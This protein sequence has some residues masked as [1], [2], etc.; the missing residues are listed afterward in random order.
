MNQATKGARQPK[1]S[2]IAPPRFAQRLL[3]W[4]CHP[5]LLEEI[6]GDLYEQFIERV[7][8]QGSRKAKW[9]YLLE[10]IR[11]VRPFT[12][13]RDAAPTQP[14]MFVD[15]IRSYL[16]M[17]WRNLSR[18]TGFALLSLFGLAI[19]MCVCFLILLFVHDELGYDKFHK[20]ADRIYRVTGQAN[21]IEIARTPPPLGPL[22]TGYFPEIEQA[23]RL[24][25]RSASLEA[26]DEATPGRM[27]ELYQEERFYFADSTV[28]RIFSFH[29]LQGDSLG[30]LNE[31][32][33]VVITEKMARK[34]FGSVSPMGRTLIFEG[35]YPFK[36]SGV[37]KEFPAQSHLHFDFMASYQSMF[38]LESEAVREDLLRNWVITHSFTY[39]LLRPQRQA[40][41]VNARFP[42]LLKKYNPRPYIKDQRYHLGPLLDI[43]LRSSVAAEAEAQG[44]LR[45]V[46]LFAAIALL[47]LLIACI[48]FINLSTARAIKRA[49]EVGVRKVLGAG[50][51]QLIG[52][53]LGESLLMSLVAFICAFV[54]TA[55][56]LPTFNQ[57]TDKTLSWQSLFRKE[58]FLGFVA[59]SIATGLLAGVY[60]AFVLAGFRPVD[61][62]KGNTFN[63]RVGSLSLRKALIV[64]QFVVAITLIACA[65]VI[66]SQLQ[67]LQN[68]PLG[69]QKQHLITIPVLSENFN[70]QV[71]GGIDASLRSR[72]TTLEEALL[73]HPSLQSSTL[74]SELPGKG[75]IRRATRPQGFATDDLIYL[76]GI[77]VDYD[78]IKTFGIK[79]L[80]GRDFSP[81]Y[82]T[83]HLE[84][85]IINEKAVKEFGWKNPEEAL[86]K[87][88]WREG[89]EGKVIGVIKDF[90]YGSLKEPIHGFLIDV[91]PKLF[92]TLSLKIASTNISQTLTF[93]EKTWRKHFPEKVFDYA[94]LDEELAHLYQKEQRLGKL[95]SLFT[96][97]AML[98]SSLGVYGL[99]TFMTE[100]RKKEIGIRKVLGASPS[101]IVALL[102]SELI[103]LVL[104]ACMLACPLAYWA[105]HNWLENFTFHISLHPW[106]FL[107]ACLSALVIALLTA[108]YHA[109]RA[110]LTNPVK[111][112]RDD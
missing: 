39:V 110:S 12:L 11:F 104:I 17:G 61:T 56:F 38:A 21:G 65:L 89:K 96:L 75:G 35:K 55:L 88:I 62:L 100:R 79:L 105:M 42:D 67:Y 87:T 49:R 46:Y 3:Q 57:L 13:Y 111:V 31:P 93:I 72:L 106:I 53:F 109:I 98:I 101:G 90:H 66:L 37:V 9:F 59:V 85:F 84:A 64:T 99:I 47:T 15:L 18:H 71:F 48:N 82:G 27:G 8:L 77:S 58:V 91:R 19:G 76:S 107:L 14:A 69:F 29:F 103:A 112:L 92:T 22:L 54:L 41:A 80:A 26:P 68:R 23:A 20:K 25:K 34:Y 70:A 97:L 32:F 28:F 10:V 60:P 95:I 2:K 33:S 36:V 1:D 73:T 108:S 74:S 5:G 43:H 81:N 45:D 52:Q 78:F 50:R 24:Y 16:L 102:S 94:F 7:G 30:S 83:D 44:S 63:Q 51:Y 6:Q 40:E 86:G 4:Y